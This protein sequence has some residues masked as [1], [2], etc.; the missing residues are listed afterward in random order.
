MSRTVRSPRSPANTISAFCSGVKVRYFLFSLIPLLEVQSDQH[1]QALRL[2]QPSTRYRGPR[3]SHST[4]TS[5]S[6]PCG[7]WSTS[8]SLR[9]TAALTS[10]LQFGLSLLVA[11]STPL[12]PPHPGPRD[13]R[14]PRSGA[15]SPPG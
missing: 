3:H 12:T 13:P 1:P 9:W 14:L 10:R 4:L 2:R 5:R 7:S 15:R 11:T 6:T 8:R